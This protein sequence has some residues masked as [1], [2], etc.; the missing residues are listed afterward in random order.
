VT[1]AVQD[2]AFKWHDALTSKVLDNQ[3][4]GVVKAQLLKCHGTSRSQI[5]IELFFRIKLSLQSAD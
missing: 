2:W 4:C 3:D 5:S 1:T